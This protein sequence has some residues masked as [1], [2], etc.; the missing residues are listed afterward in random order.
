MRKSKPHRICQ[1]HRPPTI[2]YLARMCED[3]GLHTLVDAFVLLK[4]RGTLGVLLLIFPCSHGW[5]PSGSMAT[6]AGLV[7][8]LFMGLLTF[9]GLQLWNEQDQ[10]AEANL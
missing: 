3:K 9:M 2:G 1:L 10:L 5:V 4:D 8:T 7:M 6:G